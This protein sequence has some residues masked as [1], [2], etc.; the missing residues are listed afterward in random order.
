MRTPESSRASP[1]SWVVSTVLIPFT[2][3]LAQLNML[4]LLG[5]LVT[6]YAFP[7]LFVLRSGVIDNENV[8]K[9]GTPQFIG[10]AL[11]GLALILIS[12]RTLFCV[13][14]LTT[15]L[16]AALLL[17]I[18]KVSRSVAPTLPDASPPRDRK[19]LWQQS[20]FRDPRVV[21]YL[22]TGIVYGVGVSALQIVLLQVVSV[23]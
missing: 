19:R 6:I 16:G 7:A 10:P 21:A 13:E 15:I 4:S 12:V 18:P 14:T 5:G 8:V 23:R 20:F 1:W 9:G 3:S 11:A 17:G 22:F 2:Q